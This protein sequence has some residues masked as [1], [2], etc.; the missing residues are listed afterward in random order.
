VTGKKLIDEYRDMV[1][2]VYIEK[3]N[4]EEKDANLRILRKT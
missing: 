1:S 4:L 3:L 2:K